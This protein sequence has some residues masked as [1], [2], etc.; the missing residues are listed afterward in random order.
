MY[1]GGGTLSV[2]FPSQLSIRSH[3]SHSLG[4]ARLCLLSNKFTFI[5]RHID[6]GGLL[7]SNPLTFG[8]WVVDVNGCATYTRA[9]VSLR[10]VQRAII[11]TQALPY[12][13]TAFLDS[14]ELPDPDDDLPHPPYTQSSKRKQGRDE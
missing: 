11:G 10:G 8:S 6:W 14:F 13:P 2:C 3:S 12:R 9:G 7:S 4:R 1:A 5:G